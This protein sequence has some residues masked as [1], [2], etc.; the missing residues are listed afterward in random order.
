MRVPRIGRFV[1]VCTRW[2]WDDAADWAEKR[3]WKTLAKHPMKALIEE[4]TESDAVILDSQG[5]GATADGGES[6]TSQGAGRR[7]EDNLPRSTA[8]TSLQ[9]T[10]SAVTYRSYWPERFSVEELLQMRADDPRGF[11]QQMQN[12]VAPEEGL[13]FER[14]WFT[15]RFDVPPGEILLRLDTWDTAAGQGRNRSFS[16]GL[17]A[18]V[19]RDFHIYLLNMLRA[20]LPY[21]DL[22]E[23]MRMTA[24]R[25]KSNAVIIE[26]KS[27]GQ[28]AIQELWQE[29]YPIVAFQ[30]FG[31]KGSPA[32]EE[33]NV[34]TS[35]ICAQRRVHLP[36]DYFC[37]QYGS[38]DWLPDF[39]REVFSYP[40][41]E[42][43]D[44]VDA[45]C[46]MLWW[47]EEQR[48]RHQ[49]FVR[50][51]HEPQDW[52]VSYKPEDQKMLV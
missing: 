21:P 40:D 14:I 48:L 30:P 50:R 36:T 28:Q 22:K 5:G 8:D 43:D 37:R 23:A 15:D 33:G 26:A 35:D 45:L 27:S 32:R 34:R 11:A 25:N 2:A 13:V 7:D 31:Q 24:R 20:Q 19:S 18:A 39:E 17:S 4:G 52:G 41:G 47:V 12:E 42:H 29:G 3:R 16:V 1:M 38:R 46:Q 9:S 6:A 51:S 49:Q 44:I 10:S